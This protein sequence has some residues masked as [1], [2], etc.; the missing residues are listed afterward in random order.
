MKV[1]SIYHYCLEQLRIRVV[2]ANDGRCNTRS[3]IVWKNLLE[4]EI[5]KQ[6]NTFGMQ[7]LKMPEA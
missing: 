1:D 2:A 7:G 4:K 5:E 6:N 3:I